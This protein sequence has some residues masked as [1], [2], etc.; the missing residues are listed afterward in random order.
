MLL[1]RRS[2]QSARKLTP[3]PVTLQRHCLH[4]PH[5]NKSMC[6]SAAPTGNPHRKVGMWLLG[7]SGAVFGMVVVGGLTR[8][9]RSGLSIVEWKPHSVALPVT[10]EQWDEEFDK[11]KQYP[12][13]KTVNR[14]MTLEEFKV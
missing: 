11:Y 14:N 4:S 13:F 10:A 3:G 7:C 2:L 6:S 8:L 1:L 12:E 5:F 9:T